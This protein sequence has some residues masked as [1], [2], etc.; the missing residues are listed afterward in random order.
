[1]DTEELRRLNEHPC[2][3][4]LICGSILVFPESDGTESAGKPRTLVN[5]GLV[6]GAPICYDLAI[7]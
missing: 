3:S 4:V 2:E 5:V 6:A 7:G 1:M